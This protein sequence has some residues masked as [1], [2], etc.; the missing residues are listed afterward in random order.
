MKVLK[1]GGTSVGSIDSILKVKQIVES[2]KEPVIVVVSALGGIT[3]QLIKVSN[4]AVAGG[5]D[6]L[7]LLGDIICRHETMIKAVIPAGEQQTRVWKQVKSLLDEL[8]NI[9][10][11]VSLLQDL[12]PKT[13]DIILSYG[14]RIS[15]II[16]A[17]LI[18]AKHYD[19][20]NFIKTEVKHN[21]RGLAKKLTEQLVC[22]TF[23]G[24]PERCLVPGFIS[25]DKESGVIT[26]LGRGGSDYTASVI[27]AALEASAL[28]ISHLQ[29]TSSRASTLLPM[30]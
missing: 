10:R 8:S 30:T 9:L 5:D 3:D 21:K 16:V 24:A 4:M 6:Y 20:R 1:F 15:S 19:A 27:A 26:N 7:T 11:G 14:E 13:T 25:T 12:S 2:E 29:M 28:E 23:Q 17:E 22:E 18:N